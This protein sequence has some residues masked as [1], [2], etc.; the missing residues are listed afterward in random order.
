MGYVHELTKKITCIDCGKEFIVTAHVTS[1]NRC[2]EC[3]TVYR[4]KY[5][6]EFE[7]RKKEKTNYN[8]DNAFK[9]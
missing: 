2:N 6:R 8:L 3:Y 1:K 7:A 5:K 9:R 4:R